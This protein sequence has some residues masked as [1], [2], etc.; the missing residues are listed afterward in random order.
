MKHITNASFCIIH[1]QALCAKSGLTSFDNV[2]AV[3]TKIVNLISSQALNKQKFDALL[4]EDNSVYNGLL[5]YNNVRWL[6]RRN[7]LQR[8]VDCLEEIRLFL[9]NEGK[10]QQYYSCWML[11]GFQ[12]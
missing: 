12:N 8:F 3:V 7:V 1:Q 6:N 9:Q 5:M 10:I 11:C 4:D 2:M